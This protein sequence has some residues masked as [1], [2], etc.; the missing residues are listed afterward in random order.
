MGKGGDW[1]ANGNFDKS[2]SSTSKNIY[3]WSEIRDNKKWI[4]INNK[5]YDVS[6]FSKR[7]PGGERLL[8]N[9][10][11]WFDTLFFYLKLRKLNS[12]IFVYRTRRYGMHLHFIGL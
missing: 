11:G 12:N 9:H 3:T 5:V 7:H 8:M 1:S 6:N 2:E 10:I 4:V